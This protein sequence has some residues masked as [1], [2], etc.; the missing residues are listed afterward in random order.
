MILVLEEDV[1]S[2]GEQALRIMVQATIKRSRIF[3]IAD[4][5]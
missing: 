4:S 2:L 5:F 1:E 3:F